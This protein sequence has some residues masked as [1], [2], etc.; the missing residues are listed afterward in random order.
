M[1]RLE[2]MHKQVQ[3]QR[4]GISLGRKHGTQVARLKSKRKSRAL[5]YNKKTPPSKGIVTLLNIVLWNLV[6]LMLILKGLIN[7]WF[8]GELIGV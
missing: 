8:K 3:S 5:E 1:T 2:N 7:F 6:R 4:I